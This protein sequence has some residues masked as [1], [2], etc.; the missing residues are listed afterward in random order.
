M[1]PDVE[2][3]GYVLSDGCRRIAPEFALQVLDTLKLDHTPSLYQIWYAR[4]RGV[5]AAWPAWPAW[6]VEA[7]LGHQYNLGYCM[8]MNKFSLDHAELEVI[9]WSK[10]LLSYFNR[11]IVCLLSTWQVKFTSIRV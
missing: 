4:C 5:I 2:R 6:L 10:Y 8:S 3:N 11:Y 7:S 1:L 9:G